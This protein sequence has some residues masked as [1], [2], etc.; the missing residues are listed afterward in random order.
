MLQSHMRPSALSPWS[1]IIACNQIKAIVLHLEHKE[2][3]LFVLVRM[4]WCD[5]ITPPDTFPVVLNTYY[6]F[7]AT[8]IKITRHRSLVSFGQ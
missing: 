3:V 5:I 1:E 7:S 8:S 6:Y 2:K 4:L